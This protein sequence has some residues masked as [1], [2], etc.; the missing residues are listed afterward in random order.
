MTLRIIRPAW[1]DDDLVAAAAALTASN[2]TESVALYNPATPYAVGNRVRRDETHKVYEALT[3]STGK[4]PELN[5]SGTSPAWAE[6]SASNVYAMLDAVN[7]S[8]TSMADVIDVTLTPGGFDA[9][10]LGGLNAASVDVTVTV[11]ATV[12]YDESFSLLLDNV[13]SW[14]EWL[15]ED[16]VR[17]QDLVLSD[18]PGYG[19]AVL[20]VVI[21]QAGGTAECGTLVVGRSRVLGEVQS[22]AGFRIKSNTTYK[23]NGFGGVKKTRRP[24]AR[25]LQGTIYAPNAMFDEVNRTMMEHDGETLLYSFSDTYKTLNA[26]GYMYD[27]DSTVKNE[28]G[29]FYNLQVLGLI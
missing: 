12:V 11:G 23:E 2:V 7:V 9:L 22:A 8:A 1:A 25:R 5:L 16:I 10:Y 21:H 6:V 28:S 17:D 3:A 20:R 13:F 26:L 19:G 4:T 18:L 29:F 15:N 24:A 14:Y 27:F